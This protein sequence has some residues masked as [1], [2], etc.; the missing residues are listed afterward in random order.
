MKI[1]GRV[2]LVTGGAHRL[3]KSIALALARAGAQVLISYNRATAEAAQTVR[4]IESLGAQAVAIKADQ[5][6]LAQI[7]SLFATIRERLGRLDIVVNSAAIMER[8]PVLDITPDDWDRTLETNLRGPFFVAQAAARLM[9]DLP[10]ATEQHS[11]PDSSHA[12]GR[13][14]AGC[15]V[16]IA[17]VSALR[18]WPTYVAHTVSKAGLVALTKALAVALAPSI[19]VNAIAPGAVLKPAD[20]SDERWLTLAARAPLG[21]PGAPDDVAQAV[22]YLVQSDFVTGQLLVLDGGR[23]LR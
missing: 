2:A 6:D 19:R 23:E 16:N 1:S 9:L 10:A 14:V 12:A 15:I 4:E 3:G 11:A 17:D 7:D 13:A 21:R 5:R 20:W 22:L 18:P 8:R